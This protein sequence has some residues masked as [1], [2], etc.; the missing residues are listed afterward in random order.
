MA[1]EQLRWTGLETER[2]LRDQGWEHLSVR[3]YGKS[4]IIIYSGPLEDPEPR[5][6]L[7]HLGRSRLCLDMRSSRG[8]WEP[9]P[10]F[11]TL[12]DLLS[13]LTDDFDFV[14]AP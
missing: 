6:R 2:T 13:R 10:F 7:V 11:G 5:A 9:T 14:L 8:R 4:L 3:V 1:D 12:D